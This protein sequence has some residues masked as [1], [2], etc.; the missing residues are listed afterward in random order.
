MR[1]TTRGQSVYTYEKVILNFTYNL[2]NLQFI[3]K[4]DVS[5]AKYSESKY[6]KE[7]QLAYFI[8]I[9]KPVPFSRLI[10]W[11]F[12]S[13]LHHSLLPFLLYFFRFVFFQVSNFSPFLCPPFSLDR[14]I[15]LPDTVMFIFESYSVYMYLYIHVKHHSTKL[16]IECITHV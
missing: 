3:R 9:K 12:R 15:L 14:I 7:R 10:L 16:S 2:L 4:L 6:D 1:W 5:N 8:S 11:L 13:V